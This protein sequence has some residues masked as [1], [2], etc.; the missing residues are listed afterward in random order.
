MSVREEITEPFMILAIAGSDFDVL[1]RVFD[2]ATLLFDRL[3]VPLECSV[4]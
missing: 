1:E 2:D 4:R 3:E